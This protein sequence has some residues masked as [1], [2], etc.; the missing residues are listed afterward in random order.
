[1]KLYSEDLTPQGII[2]IIE[3]AQEDDRREY[4]IMYELPWETIGPRLL[5]YLKVKPHEAHVEAVR[6]PE[7]N[8]V[9]I[10]G[11]DCLGNCWFLTTDRVTSHARDFCS[12][13]K[14][15]RDIVTDSWGPCWNIVMMSN[16]VHVRFLKF[17]GAVFDNPITLGNELFMR[18]VIHPK[19]EPNV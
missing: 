19:G 4:E 2:E 5:E 7:G 12:L 6:D 8:L 15:R 3:H 16:R 10:G 17:L 18:F 9:A 13:I 1:M 11:F 14:H